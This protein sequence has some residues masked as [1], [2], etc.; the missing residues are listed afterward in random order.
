M[1]L[2]RS[3]FARSSSVCVRP[4]IPQMKGCL[5]I[6]NIYDMPEFPLVEEYTAV[7]TESGNVRIERILSTGQVSNWYDQT[8]TEFVAL[9]DGRAVIEYENGESINMVKGD[10]LLIKPHE[11]HRVS[12]TSAEPPCVWLCVYY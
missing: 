6:M 12:Y 7:L 9:I 4:F 8:E 5:L 2:W 10:T 3:D 1:F 11:R